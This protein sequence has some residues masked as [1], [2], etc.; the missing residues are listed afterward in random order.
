MAIACFERFFA[1]YIAYAQCNTKQACRNTLRTHMQRELRA[2]FR[3]ERSAF[4]YVPLVVI[5]C[6]S[7]TLLL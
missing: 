4:L 5:E 1:Y 2:I 7:A 6:I 3:S